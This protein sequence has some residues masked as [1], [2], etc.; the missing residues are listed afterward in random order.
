MAA[1]EKMEG[2]IKNGAAVPVKDDNATN[3]GSVKLNIDCP[4]SMVSHVERIFA[5]EYNLPYHPTRQITILDIGANIGGFALWAHHHW[6]G[7]EIHCYE[8]LPYNLD[9]LNRNL[10]SESN[11][12]VHACA[13]G[14]NAQKGRRLYLGANNDGENS[15]IQLG[16]QREEFINIDVVSAR[17][18]PSAEIIKLDTEGCELEILS[19]MAPIEADVVLLEYHRESDR[20]AIDD[21]LGDYALVGGQIYRRGRGVLKYM[22]DT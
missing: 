22:K 18:L 1:E 21:L 5:G 4:P 16:E 8:P 3:S 6:P 7:A 9:C 2:D 13:V 10:C 15:F 17:E 12:Q 11:I 19:A 14:A 20:R